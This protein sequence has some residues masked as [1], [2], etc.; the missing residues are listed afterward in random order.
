MDLLLSNLVE[1][2]S[3]ITTKPS[4]CWRWGSLFQDNAQLFQGKR[5]TTWSAVT[6]TCSKL[7]DAWKMKLGNPSPFVLVGSD[8]Q[9]TQ[10]WEPV[11]TH[12][13][14]GQPDA[15]CWCKEKIHHISLVRNQQ[16]LVLI[17]QL[18]HALPVFSQLPTLWMMWY[19][20]RP[21]GSST[22]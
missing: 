21:A 16:A 5:S 1:T 12:A 10:D 17:L 18:R 22:Q 3:K 6:S 7:C 14:F 15:P 9:N 13:I 4:S 19:L 2:R 8:V 20:Q 11:S